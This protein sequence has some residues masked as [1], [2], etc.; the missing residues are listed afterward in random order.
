MLCSRSVYVHQVEVFMVDYGLTEI[1]SLAVV[2]LFSDEVMA[3][4][5]FPH[6]VCHVF[7]TCGKVNCQVH[8]RQA[9]S[10]KLCLYRLSCATRKT[11]GPSVA[12]G[13]LMSVTWLWS[14]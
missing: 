10:A 1:V 5:D 6:Q 3:L 14:K 7:T 12:C 2:R 4:H 8:V 9:N 11:T 13:V